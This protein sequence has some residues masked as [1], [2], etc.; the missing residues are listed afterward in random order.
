[1]KVIIIGAGIGG[2]VTALRLHHKGIDCG[3]YEQSEPIRELGVGINVLP[4]AVRELAEVGLLERLVEAGI[5]THEL[6]YTHRLG[7]EIMRR[8]C[9]RNAGFDPPQIS[10]HRGRL[11]SVLLQ[12][13]RE[14]LGADAVRTGHRLVGFFQDDDEVR[15]EFDD[16]RRRARVRVR[17]EV[18][19]GAD[20]IHSTVRSVLFPQE[21]PPRWNGV[22]MWRGATGWPQFGTGRTMII[23]GGNEAKLV[24][25][26]IAPGREPGTR[27]TNW[28]ICLRTGRPGDPP[29]QRQD[30]SRRVD[31]SG[32]DSQL[33][34]FRTPLIDH[35]ALV[36]AT[37]DCFEFPMC[38]RDPLPYWTRPEEVIDPGELEAIVNSYAQVSGASREQV[39]RPSGEHRSR[40]DS[41]GPP[42]DLDNKPAGEVP[43]SPSLR[44]ADR[45][46]R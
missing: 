33:A 29:P 41:V 34:P 22:M 13:V 21:G 14:R 38:D 35:A 10:L 28:A 27:L 6:I 18:L 32:L 24:L 20:G 19:V 11:Q 44:P 46:Q 26:P 23:A 39:N 16:R 2:V 31:P 5:Q 42:Q 36:R 37:R 7:Q 15:A 40:R 3:I 17:G 12:A 4:M 25:Y 43:T 9:G 45:G 1:M 30:W 8:P